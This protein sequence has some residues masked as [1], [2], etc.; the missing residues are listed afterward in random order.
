VKFVLGLSKPILLVAVLILA[1]GCS[2]KVASEASAAKQLDLQCLTTDA[3]L[4]VPNPS[5]PGSGISL[6]DAA[7]SI[8]SVARIITVA[9]GAAEIVW[10]LG[11]GDSLVGKDLVSVFPNSDD[12]V[13]VNPGHELALETVLSLK[14]SIVIADSSGESSVELEK[15]VELGIPVVVIPEATSLIEINPRIMAVATALGVIDSGNSLINQIDT[16]LENAISVESRELRIAF[17]YLRG[18]AGIY[19][20]GGEG[21]G[22]DSMITALGSVDVGTQLGISGFA[23]L[24]AESLA[25]AN[26]DVILVMN[27]GLESVGGIEKLITLPG[28]SS[29]MAAKNR[30]I[31]QAD[32]RALLSFGPQTPNVISCLANQ[33]AQVGTTSS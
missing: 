2:S 30:A 1:T 5:L 27:K 16:K 24:T 6:K 31:I 26:P 4:P 22:A 28:V 19:L 13:T 7:V 33:L 21:S 29:T 20:L 8:E 3:A 12:I 14:P 10:S 25:Q 32:D 11:L 23:P 17:L 9:P 18:N 15:L